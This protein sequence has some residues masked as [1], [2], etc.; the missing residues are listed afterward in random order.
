VSRKFFTGLV[1]M[2]ALSIIGITWVQIVWI[3]NAIDKSNENFNMAVF[4]SLNNAAEEIENARKM[5]SFNNFLFHDPVQIIDS[6]AGVSGYFSYGSTITSDGGT[7]NINITNRVGSVDRNGK[8]RIIIVTDTS[9]TDTVTTVTGKDG[10]QAMV[11]SGLENRS[12]GANTS[13][14]VNSKEFKD[15]LKTRSGEFANMSD[16]MLMEIYESERAMNPGIE[17]I[18]NALKYFF[19]FYGIRTPFEFAIIKDGKLSAVSSQ[20]P[21]VNE[22]QRSMYKVRLFPNNLIRRDLVLS[23]VFPGKTNYV[24]GSMAWILG[25]S[26][27]FSLFIFSTFALSLFFI[28]RQKKISEMKSDFLNN[29]THEFK[30]PIATISLAADTITN[31]KV[32]NDENSIRHFVGMIK[33]ENSRMNKQVETILQ[34]ASLDKREIDFRFEKTSLHS[35]VGRAI[36]TTEIQVHQKQG[37]IRTMLSA[38]DD[39]VYG[40]TEHLTNLVNNLLDNAIKYSPEYPDIT[41]STENRQGGIVLSVEDKGIGMS[42]SVQSRIFERFYRQASGDVHDVKGF[43]LGLNYVRAIVDAHKGNITVTSEP[44]RGSRFE[45]YLPLNTEN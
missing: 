44:G 16:Q 45:I 35:I 14:N 9:Y 38:G 18:R 19:P 4:S 11:W 15:W 40:D 43:G 20:K 3:K 7:V 42:K 31:P 13:L 22:F 8:Q 12:S 33:K 30:T 26:L 29:M 39:M 23:V 24:L 41:L 32:I 37:K 10:R 25:G 6:S 2:M 36:E 21:A 28:L 34:I 17:E 27:L 1:F 5:N